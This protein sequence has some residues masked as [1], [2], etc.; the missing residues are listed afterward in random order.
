M[1][2]QEKLEAFRT[3]LT[4]LVEKYKVDLIPMI[5]VNDRPE[6]VEEAVVIKEEKPA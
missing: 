3:E 4:Q 1:I 2:S 5:S 6:T